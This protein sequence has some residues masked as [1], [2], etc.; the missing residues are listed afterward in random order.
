MEMKS[1]R[2]TKAP[3]FM[4]IVADSA[5]ALVLLSHKRHSEGSKISKFLTNIQIEILIYL[6]FT[7]IIYCF[8][9]DLGIFIL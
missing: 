5:N 3:L 1:H 4:R 7:V 6:I 8:R 2:N 9:L